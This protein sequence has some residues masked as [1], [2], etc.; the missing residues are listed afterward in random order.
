MDFLSFTEEDWD[1]LGISWPQV[2]YA[3]FLAI[4]STVC[5][6]KETTSMDSKDQATRCNRDVLVCTDTNIDAT[7]DPKNNQGNNQH[8]NNNGNIGNGDPPDNDN[9]K[10]NKHNACTNNECDNKYKQGYNARFDT[11]IAFAPRY[12][13]NHKDGL[14][15]NHAIALLSED[16][17][18][19][20]DK[21]CNASGRWTDSF[22]KILHIISYMYNCRCKTAIA[23]GTKENNL[24]ILHL[25]AQLK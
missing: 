21:Q 22:Y 3:A 4:Y 7:E 9:Y 1:G 18:G 8:R 20:D 14:N 15:A 24:R 19:N 6:A 10:A 13:S 12:N 23:G 5:M 11:D 16:D 17:D 2:N 25:H